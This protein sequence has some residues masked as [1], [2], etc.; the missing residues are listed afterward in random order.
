M[1]TDECIL[2][3]VLDV[4]RM[5]HVASHMPRDAPLVLDDERLECLRV[6]RLREPHEFR[7]LVCCQHSGPSLRKPA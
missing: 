7:I 5:A 3:H 6:A 1:R 2:D 4:A